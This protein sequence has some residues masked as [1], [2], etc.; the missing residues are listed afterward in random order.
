[1]RLNAACCDLAPVWREA[2]ADL[3]PTAGWNT[4]ELIENGLADTRVLADDFQM[5]RVFRNLFEN[6]F[7]AVTGPLLMT[8]YSTLAT[9]GQ[10][11]A[12]RFSIRDNGP[13][14]SNAARARIFD[15]FFTTKTRGTGLG[16]ALCKRVV[17]EQGGRIEAGRDGP[18]AEVIITLPKWLS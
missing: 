9:L 10:R 12:L 5:R 4:A 2:W 14:F 1:V 6:A 17:N 8:I 7:A 16:L 11:P 18:G 3:A 13:G 15:A